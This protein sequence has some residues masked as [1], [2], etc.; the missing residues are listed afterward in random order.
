MGSGLKPLC[1]RV[2]ALVALGT[3]LAAIQTVVVPR[4]ERSLLI[5]FVYVGMWMLFSV[6]RPPPQDI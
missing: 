3:L 5:R 4:A 2:G 1:S 6:L